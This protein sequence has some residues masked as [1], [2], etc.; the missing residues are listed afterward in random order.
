MLS[1]Q[2]DVTILS[3]QSLTHESTFCHERPTYFFFPFLPSSLI[4][5]PVL[6][7]LPSM[8]T[9]LPSMM[10]TRERPSQFLKE[11]TTSGCCGTNM[12]SAISLAL[13][14]CGSSI[15]FPPVSFPIFHINCFIRTAER[16]VRT[17]HTGVYPTLSSPGWSRTCTCAV[18]VPASFNVPSFLYTI[19]SP[20]RGMLSLLRPLT[21]RPTLSPAF[22]SSQRLWCISQVNTFPAHALEEECCGRKITSSP[23]FT[24][25]CST[26]PV[27]TSPTPLIL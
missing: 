13:R 16:P 25:P 1:W 10:A 3:A 7:T 14:Q 20:V 2:C 21:L 11:S 19:T 18:K 4:F 15:F 6:I 22:A 8:T 23:G 12:T 9:P 17:K 26:R 5:S 27:I 24:M